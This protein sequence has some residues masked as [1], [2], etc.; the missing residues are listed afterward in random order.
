ME[1]LGGISVS[2]DF[3]AG[4]FRG[5]RVL[6]TGHTGFKG[7][8]LS[9]MLKR[10]GAAV[11]GYAKE[12]PTS[13]S[14]FEL[15]SVG[16]GM[17]SVL[18]DVRDLGALLEVFRKSEPEIVFH[19]AAQPLV[20]EGYRDPVS[21]YDTNV[22]GTVHVLECVRQCPSVR[23]VVVVTTD[24]VYQNKEQQAGYA[25]GDRLGGD[26]PYAS[27]KACAELVAGAFHTSFLRERGVGMCT[28]RAGNVIGGGDFAPD[29]ILP[30]CVRAALCDGELCLRYP[31]SVRPYQHVLEPLI[32]YLRIAERLWTHPLPPALNVG[33]DMGDCL[34]TLELVRCFE[35][36]WGSPIRLK[37]GAEKAPHEAGLL[38]LCCSEIR[39]TLGW[40]PVWTA[41]VAVEKTVEWVR[42]WQ[43]GADV[44]D[45]MDAQIEE[46]MHL[47]I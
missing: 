1:A 19:L 10:L 41:S 24:K 8:W 13:P 4:F 38:R 5:K 36:A 22:M 27:S 25:E 29:R 28:V 33:P 18:G 32:A 23:A 39:R 9:H 11:T 16:E 45:V 30:D 46:Y 6:V 15:A 47:M 43:T 44:R 40:A 12:P 3:C 2:A 14:L 35:R 34:E 17:T 31:H 21:T 7:A 26:D 20:R 37:T 42:A